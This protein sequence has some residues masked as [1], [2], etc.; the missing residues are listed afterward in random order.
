MTMK[1]IADR[2]AKIKN[3]LIAVVTDLNKAGNFHT[4]QIAQT[5]VM[6]AS[7]LADRCANEASKEKKAVP[8]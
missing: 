3:D 8:E 6:N 7:Q 5:S 1:Q 4:A 2:T